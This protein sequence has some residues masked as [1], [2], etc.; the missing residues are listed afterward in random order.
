MD[1]KNKFNNKKFK[2]GMLYFLVV[3]GSTWA[4]NSAVSSLYTEK[5]SYS[6]FE[7]WGNEGLIKEI[8]VS[9][10]KYEIS[11]KEDSGLADK[12]YIVKPMPEA[13]SNKLKEWD[14]PF[15][16]SV[17]VQRNYFLEFFVSWVLPLLVFMLIWKYFM[18]GM[19]KKMGGGVMS[20]G[21]N[22]P[23]IYAQKETGITFKDVAGQDEA[24]ES[25][26]ELVDFLD[27]PEKYTSI[28]AKL[29]K[30]ALLVGPPGTGKTLLAKAVAGEAN[31]PFFSM[32]GSEFVQMFVGMGASKVRDLFAQAQK[33]APCIVF[34]DEIDTIGKSRENQMNSNDEREQTLNQLLSEMDGFDSSKGVVILGATNRPEVLDQALLR[35]G[36]FDRRIIVDRPDLDGRK[37]ILQ[38]HAKKVKMSEEVD[39]NA[40][41]KTTSG[42]SGAELA[43]LINEAAILAVK[44]KRN[45]VEQCDLEE[46]FEVI[47][48]GKI[49]KDR[50]LSEK[51]KRSVAF[52]E[53]GH[54]LIAEL[55]PN[56]DKVHKITIIPRTKGSLGFTM[57]LP[58]ED[59]YLIT[60]EEMEDK[61]TIMLGGRA[62]EEV[63]FNQ[64]STGASNDIERAT[65]TARRMVT[66]YGMSERFDMMALES[67]NSAYLD[68]RPVRNCSDDTG[69]IIDEETLKI[70][71][72]QHKK[73]VEMLTQNKEILIEASE[74]L[75]EHET[76]TG[77]Q[78]NEIINKDSIIPEENILEKENIIE[79][80]NIIDEE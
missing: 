26:V 55:L 30:G 31:V 67:M 6:K 17:P 14:V 37:A 23:K 5:I 60:K 13:I 39:L 44:N 74:F 28:G 51:E 75:L 36:R 48:A 53:I 66:M 80:K 54:A 72:S 40:L 70:I 22:S 76:I 45:F 12:I 77:K 42:T 43:N 58:T 29:P 50:I 15:Y 20:F 32:S 79:E 63:M 52:H 9:S 41:A 1:M 38:V 57:Q 2:I 49:K 65:N 16:D 61:I 64:I 27:S 25:L 19:E 73:A 59:K 68:G 69:K 11:L 18:K 35:P 24:K 7:K 56:A 4:L 8:K 3:I 46:A 33:E 62:A 21:K 34:I 71:V 78:F 10:D 47:I